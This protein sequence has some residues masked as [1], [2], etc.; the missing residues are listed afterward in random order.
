MWFQYH[1]FCYY[2]IR[3]LGI[4]L[5]ACVHFH[6]LISISLLYLLYEWSLHSQYTSTMYSTWKTAKTVLLYIQNISYKSHYTVVS[7]KLL[8]C[9]VAALRISFLTFRRI[10]LPSSSRS[11]SPRWIPR[12]VTRPAR[13][14]HIPEDLSV[15]HTAVRCSTLA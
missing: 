5:H 7:Y 12:W 6:Y 14:S 8:E 10:V 9:D 4:G 1:I 11:S 15:A 2:N 13:W 3:I